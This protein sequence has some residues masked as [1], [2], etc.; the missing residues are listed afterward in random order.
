[1]VETEFLETATQAA[2]EAGAILQEWR[3]KFTVSQ[4][5]GPADLVT[6]ADLA[7]QTAI[8]RR[9]QGRFPEHAFLGEESLITERGSSPYRWV[10]DP[11]DGTGNY[12]HG[13]PYYAVSIGLERDDELVLGVIYD[14][15]RDEMFTAIRGGG[16]MLN[17]SPIQASRVDRLGAALVVAS[18]PHGVRV[19]SPVISD[20]LRVLSEAQSVQRTGSAALN[21][22]YV[23]MGR[24]DAFW[25]QSLKPWDMAA[26]VLLVQEAGGRVTSRGGAPIDIHVPDMVSSNG[27]D[28]HEELLALLASNA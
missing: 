28:V 21:L 22:A 8:H 6:E 12:V 27:T 9:I 1:M 10:I 20:F 24:F 15:T 26:G 25:S 4:K 19:E 7:A 13:N 2:R 3:T 11:L 17:G 16:A 23:A 5:T 18:F 14:P